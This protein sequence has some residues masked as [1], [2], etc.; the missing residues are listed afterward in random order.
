MV[1]RQAEAAKVICRAAGDAAGVREQRDT[2]EIGI[3]ADSSLAQR[4][5]VTSARPPSELASH[6]AQPGPVCSRTRRS[7]RRSSCSTARRRRNR[8]APELRPAGPQQPRV[9]NG[10]AQYKDLGKETG[11]DYDREKAKKSLEDA[12]WKAGADGYRAKDGATLEIKFSQLKG[13]KVSENEAQQ[14]QS[15]LK[16]VGIKVTLVD[17]ASKDFSPTLAKRQPVST[18]YLGGHAVPVPGYGRSSARSRPNFSLKST[19]VR[20]HREDLTEMDQTKRD[21]YVLQAEKIAW[22][23]VDHPLYQRPDQWAVNSKVANYGAFGLSSPPENIA[24]EVMSCTA[25]I[26]PSSTDLRAGGRPP[27]PQPFT[28]D[29]KRSRE[30]FLQPRDF[31]SA[32]RFPLQRFSVKFCRA[33][34]LAGCGSSRETHR[35]VRIPLVREGWTREDSRR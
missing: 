3:N 6:H 23:E 10:Q 35:G 9:L 18:Q 12:G 21:E 28:R 7:V 15:Q 2:F 27:A 1:G 4:P 19:E 24:S 20:S 29:S 14:F 32:P 5:P 17:T 34:S 16:E 31:P 22:T 33:G 11:L 26:A 13:V 25:P 30:T 8:P